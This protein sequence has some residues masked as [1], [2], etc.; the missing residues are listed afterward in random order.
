MSRVSF[1]FFATL[2]FT[3]TLSPLA[4]AQSYTLRDL[5]PLP[6]GGTSSAA[7]LNNSGIV[8]GSSNLSNGNLHAVI[9][10]SGGIHDI[11]TLGGTSAASAASGINDS[12]QVTG[13]SE[14]TNHNIWHAFSYT[15]TGGMQDLGT[16]GGQSSFGYAINN[17]GQIVGTSDLSDGVTTHA[18]LWTSAGGMQDLG[19]LNGNSY[20]LAINNAGEIVGYY[21]YSGTI[22]H[23]FAWTPAN[24]MQDIGSLD[25]ASSFAYAINN[26]GA[27]AGI[28][29]S[30]PNTPPYYRA[31][32]WSPS[33]ILEDIGA[34]P[35]SAAYAI[36]D[37]GQ[38][39]GT[40]AFGAFIWTAA[41]H[42]QNLNDLIPPNTGFM[43]YA[44]SAINR[45][46]QI[47]SGGTSNNGG[48][49]HGA[50]LT[51]VN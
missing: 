2:T 40:A 48:N 41:A 18:F 31:A 10:T 32:R 9:W 36:S 33:F 21:A 50:L 4:A 26:A 19:S 27:I 47:V 13:S 17:A 37:A 44:A 23:A 39:T 8:A 24:G 51:P 7:A 3:L 45:S 14:L 25:G 5:T 28:G 43:L 34:G 15:T 46:G 20:A 22:Y 11:G 6:N 29:F 49:T 16:L 1:L 38:I 12:G 30:T 42:I 35:E